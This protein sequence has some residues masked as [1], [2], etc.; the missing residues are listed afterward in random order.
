MAKL[1]ITGL[2]DIEESIW[3][4]K[5]GMKGKV[6]ASVHATIQVP[7]PKGRTRVT[8]QE[9]ETG[10]P[11]PFEIKTGRAIGVM[12]HRAQTMLYT[13]LMEERYRTSLPSFG[14]VQLT[15]LTGTPI[16]S[17]LLY[18]TQTDSILQVPAA[19]GEVRSLLMSRNEMAGYASRKR[20]RQER[21][22]VERGSQL[23]PSRIQLPPKK[24]EVTAAAPEVD[25]A[26]EFAFLDDAL[27]NL[28]IVNATETGLRATGITLTADVEELP[29]L[30]PTI[31][32]ERECSR[33]YASDACML[34]RRVSPPLSP[35]SDEY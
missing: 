7:T 10:G 12:E 26:D 33:C 21:Q 34:Y 31:D 13:L 16:K 14:D 23:S 35:K 27:P 17:G 4:P 29:I 11:M 5:W 19:I 15:P 24:E 32:N 3:S 18:Y 28:H 6:D 20:V 30:P 9:G 8:V 22:K 2:H 25:D 1:A